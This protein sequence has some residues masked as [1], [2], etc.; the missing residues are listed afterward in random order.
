LKSTAKTDLRKIIPGD[1]PQLK[2]QDLSQSKYTTSLTILKKTKKEKCKE[3]T[4]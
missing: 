4:S 1:G 2:N 3:Y